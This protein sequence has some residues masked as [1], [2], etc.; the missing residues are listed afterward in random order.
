[1]DSYRLNSRV[2]DDPNSLVT[3]AVELVEYHRKFVLQLAVTQGYQNHYVI[4]GSM[5]KL[6]K[7]SHILAQY[8]LVLRS[9]K[10]KI[11]VVDKNIRE[12]K[13]YEIRENGLLKSISKLLYTKFKKINEFEENGKIYKVYI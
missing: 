12:G 1:L 9:P 5:D 7:A 3:R 8:N 11:E 6:I 13:V 2:M 4:H 10:I